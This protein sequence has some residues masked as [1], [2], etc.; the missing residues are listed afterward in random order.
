[1][2]ATPS[3][4]KTP[5]QLL[6]TRRPAS[7]ARALGAVVYFSLAVTVL[8][9]LGAGVATLTAGADF[10]LAFVLV[11]WSVVLLLLVAPALHRLVLARRGLPLPYAMQT[12][13]TALVLTIESICFD[14]L[15]AQL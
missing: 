6:A 9:A 4:E 3:T 1:M 5:V 11:R 10:L 14:I 7:R 13:L 12:P 8:G 2:T 15:S